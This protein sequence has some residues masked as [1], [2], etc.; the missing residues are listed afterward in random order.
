MKITKEIRT[1]LLIAMAIIILIIGYGWLKG[2]NLL[3]KGNYFK[4]E[5]DNAN[6]L[7]K[8]DH[9]LIDGYEV[10]K[11]QSISLQEDKSGVLVELNITEQDIN[12]PVDSRAIIGGD[13]LGEKYVQITIG[14]SSQ[15]A[16]NGAALEGGVEADVQSEIKLL[17][18]KINAMIT[19]IDT[20]INVLSS[21]FTENLKEDFAK[22]ISGIKNTLESFNKSAARFNDILVKEEPRIK[23]IISNVS[24]T[25][26]Y[27]SKSEGE[28]KAIL[29]NLKSLS[30][31]LNSIQW[32][33][34][35]TELDMAM[36]NITSLTD[37][38]NSG[39]GSL[40]MM[41]NNKK[42]YNELTHTIATLDSVLV[43]FSEDPE[44]NVRLFGGKK[45]K[46]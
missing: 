33:A 28:V 46:E 44:I 43:K 14:S 1:G 8:G 4:V 12:L 42:L 23:E 22:S 24:T 25:T 36:K 20:T 13:L 37:K 10:G 5:Y 38:I 9:V 7:Q 26:D 35:S 18:G 16:Q 34:L 32:E 30:D 2:N 17:S 19:S 21:I 40:G 45:N 29:A 31:T 41:I 11:V 39:E 3:S 15:F 6:G 27:V